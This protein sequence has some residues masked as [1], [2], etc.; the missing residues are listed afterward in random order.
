MTF[1]HNLFLALNF[2]GGTAFD[3][4]MLAVS[5][6]ALWIPL[7]ILILTMV[8]RRDGWR[9]LL[10]FLFLV[11]AAIGI[12]DVVASIFKANGLLGSLLTSFEPRWRPMFTPSLEGLDI[13]PDS[14]YA[15]RRMTADELAAAGIDHTWAVHVPREAVAGRYGTVSAHAATTIALAT[16]SIAV[17]RRRWFTPLMVTASLLICYS[18]IYLAKHFPMDIVWGALLGLVLGYAAYRIYMRLNG[19]VKMKN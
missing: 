1:D 8:W 2:D 3:R 5:G 7:Y 9:S 17:I 18:R 6:N 11:A 10:F 12:A 16:M 13:A 4:A 19:A 15:L 14:L